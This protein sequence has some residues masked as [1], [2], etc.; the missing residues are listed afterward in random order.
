MKKLL[1][2]LMGPAIILTM[3]LGS[4]WLLH[5]ELRDYHLHDFLQSL[6]GISSLQIGIAL[7]LTVLNYGILLGYDLLGIRYIGHPMRLG[8][9]G[10]ASF[11][12]Y[13]VGNNF[14]TVLGGSTIRLRLYTAWGLSSVEIVKLV[15]MLSLTFWV[16][17]FAL[18]G[19]VFLVDPLTIPAK[20]HLPFSTTMPLGFLFGGLAV[21]Y[22]VL[23][24]TRRAPVK[25]WRW[26]FTPPGV[27]LSLA[28]FAIAALDLMVGAAVLYVLLPQELEIGY[29]HFLTIYMLALAAGLISQAPGGLGVIELV[30]L[31]MLDPAD[32]SRV[33]GSLLAYRAIY[34]LFPLTMGLLVMAANEAMMLRRHWGTAASLISQGAALAAPRILAVTVFV[35]GVLLLVSGATPSGEGRLRLLRGLLP[36]PVI[37]FSHLLGSIVGVLLILLARGLQRRIETAYFAALA[38]LL[39]G[40]AFSLL[41]GFDY[42]EALVLGVMLVCFLP[43]RRN[44][45]R[46]GAL[47][48]E[49]FTPAWLLTIGLVIGC[50]VWVMF[51]SYRH[52]EYS[53][54]LWWNFA[55]RADAPRSLRALAGV[56]TV[57]L[58]VACWRLLGSKPKAPAMPTPEDLDSARAIVADCPQTAAN[59]ALLGDKH[60]LFNDS[61]TG[62]L[63]FGASGKCWVAM[64]DPIGDEQAC[65]ELAWDF[66]ERCDEGDRW[67]VFYQV[68]ENR[69]PLYVDMGLTLI[70]LGEEARVPLA[71]FSLEG[72]RR[73]GLRRTQK[74]L[75][76]AGC[77]F[78]IIEPPL[79]DDLLAD[80]HRISDS[81]LAE[82]STAEKGF[83]LGFFQ[84]DYIR[85]SA[86]AVVSLQG[87]RIAF[88]NLWR[89]AGKQELSLDLMRYDPRAPHGVMEF[90]FINLMLWGHA[91]GY[92]WFN[93]GMAPL[94]GVEARRLG[95]LWNRIASLAFR[96][97]E[98][99]Y[100][101]EGLRQYKEKFDPEWKPRYLASR[102]GL[103]LPLVL[104]N[105]ATLISGGIGELVK[106]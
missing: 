71:N 6:A 25:I 69:V 36:L 61:R 39:G 58:L 18:S 22:L 23:C 33:M 76:T 30:I 90:L 65:R 52:V 102:G 101:F 26:E 21:G 70:K 1:Q 16:G 93:L 40:I 87:E 56:V 81:W 67:P 28:Q 49:R 57:T 2:T 73:K 79:E 92:Q 99:F 42:E 5:R 84:P 20:L 80:L 32:P 106:K 66:Q 27:G 62:F 82:K 55:F 53:E 4:L 75:T 17:L 96:Y 10:L 7:G 35:A 86:V 64:G 63:M 8:R 11:L 41:K 103:A 85:H 88:A 14:G 3:V 95:P 51:F 98:H 46:H 74:Q 100:N 89:G 44:F 34:Y 91:Q 24:A 43:C 47:L 54:S 29:G 77:Q 78:E 48:T 60:F 15:L 31:V 38:L 12:G 50:T 105:V 94:S 59:L 68:E 83:S 9:V 19:L 104:T 13:A 45:Y 97:G 37:E 72:G